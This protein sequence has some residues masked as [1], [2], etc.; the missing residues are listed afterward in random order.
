VQDLIRVEHVNKHYGGA[1][2]LRDASFSVAPAEVHAL[3]G[4]NGAGK[5]TLGK[6]VAGAVMPDSAQVQ[7]N[8]EPLQIE[9]P[10]S[11]QR[12]GIGIVFQELDLFPN[13]SIAEN[14]VIGNLHAER[15]YW[16]SWRDLVAFCQPYLDQVGNWPDAAC[17]Y[18]TC[19][20]FSGT[21]ARIR[22]T[23]QFTFR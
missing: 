1:W 8:G 20:Q 23:D 13:L 9:S 12:Q 15:G 16:V 18:C 3:M 6:I 4:E 22:R 21:S 11:A 5:S 2:A 7:W 10:M 14:I 17:C 19:A